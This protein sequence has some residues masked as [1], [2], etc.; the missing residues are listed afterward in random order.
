LSE[1]EALKGADPGRQIAA[2]AID[3]P[4]TRKTDRPFFM[5]LAFETLRHPHVPRAEGLARYEASKLPLPRD[6]MPVHPFDNGETTVREELLAPCSPVSTGGPGDFSGN[7]PPGR[8]TRTPSTSTRSTRAWPWEVTV[9]GT[10]LPDF[11]TVELRDLSGRPKHRVII[12]AMRDD[13]R[14]LQAQLNDPLP[15]ESPIPG[16][17]AFAPPTDEALQTLRRQWRVPE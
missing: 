14:Q 16:D 15:I 8:T 12:A 4:R 1:A 2:S 13:L 3:F 9:C 10:A 5:Y 17:S 11:R 6:F 7:S